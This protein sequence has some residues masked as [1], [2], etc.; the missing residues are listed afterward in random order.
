MCDFL[1]EIARHKLFS[2]HFLE[3]IACQELPHFLRKSPA[4]NFLISS[5]NRSPRTS[6]FPQEIGR[7]KT[8]SAHFL[9][10]SAATNFFGSFPQEIGRHKTFSAH[11]LRKSAAHL[12][13]HFLRKSA[14]TYSL[15]SSGNRLPRTSSFPQEIVGWPTSNS[16]F[17]R[18]TSK[19]TF[20]MRS[21]CPS[22]PN[23]L[24]NTVLVRFFLHLA[25]RSRSDRFSIVK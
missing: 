1:E 11:F 9:R 8:V 15:I 5:G 6:S 21:P 24:K 3:E 10:K 23:R 25:I 16:R 4:T 13:T 17:R 20:L 12:L 14:A 18:C 2:A 22:S 19:G 7:H